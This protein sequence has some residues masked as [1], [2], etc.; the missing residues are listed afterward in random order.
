MLEG[1]DLT[2]ELFIEVRT[3]GQKFAKRSDFVVVVVVVMV[4]VVTAIVFEEEEVG[5]EKEANGSAVAL[6]NASCF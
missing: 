6:L 4:V 2:V 5:V 3:S 1:N